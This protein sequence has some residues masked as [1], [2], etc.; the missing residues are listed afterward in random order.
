MNIRFS[1]DEV[2]LSMRLPQYVEIRLRT[3]NGAAAVKL[4]RDVMEHR[5]RFGMAF[6]GATKKSL[7][8]A[9]IECSHKDF[10]FK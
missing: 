9:K 8:R 6:K 7:N 1:L 10:H 2:S 3:R 5:L 4:L